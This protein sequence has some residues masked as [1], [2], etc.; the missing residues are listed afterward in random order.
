MGVIWWG[1]CELVGGDVAWVC[2]SVWEGRLGEWG[3]GG[4][5]G[6]LVRSRAVHCVGGCG[7]CGGC[8]G[9]VA[10]IKS[11]HPPLNISQ[12]PNGPA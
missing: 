7:G 9:E 6:G 4:W 8:G 3:G 11:P 2:V 1:V 12:T 10:A 5:L